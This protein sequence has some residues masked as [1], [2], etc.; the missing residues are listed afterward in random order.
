MLK[1]GFMR[2]L[3]YYYG[4]ATLT[5]T[6]IGAG[7]LGI[8]F[9]VAMSGFWTGVLVL[10]VLGI[11]NLFVNLFM[12]DIVLGS[13][14]RH[15]LVGH[16]GRILGRYGRF[17]ML[18]SIVIGCFGALVAYTLGVGSSLAEV[19]GGPV[20][21]WSALFYLVMSY[22]LAGTVSRLGKS[23]LWMEFFKL[24]VFLAVVFFLFSSSQFNVGNLSGFSWNSLLVPFGV[25]LFAYMGSPAIPEVC[26]QTRVCSHLTR[27]VIVIG[28]LI[29]LIAYVAFAAAV[30]GVTGPL[31]TEVATIGVARFSGAFV[32][33]LV[34]A[35]AV[36]AMASSFLALGYV[37]KDTFVKDVGLSSSNAWFI[38]VLAPLALIALGLSSFVRVLD[39]AGTF[40]GGIAG[41]LIVLMRALSVKRRSA[42]S[43]FGYCALILVFCV[44]MLYQASLLV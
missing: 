27:R 17:W 2:P 22:L 29:P 11:V 24:V 5:G 44:G 21:L 36:L 16:A 33:G 1:R 38:V 8:P 9:V 4:I 31:T 37:L 28:S 18:L 34:H 6:V 30:I 39:I 19:F 23:E 40:S 7:I 15:Q 13:D 32:A 43:I 14:G 3:A 41:V 20:W 26:E 35:L 10:V 42:L 12:G 25:V